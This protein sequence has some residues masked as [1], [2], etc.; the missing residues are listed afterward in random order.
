MK[1]QSKMQAMAIISLMRLLKIDN[2]SSL[3]LSLSFAITYFLT[4]YKGI[5]TLIV[6]DLK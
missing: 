6:L 5:L 4:V 3:G 1:F 2:I